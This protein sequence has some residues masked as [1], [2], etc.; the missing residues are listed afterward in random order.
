MFW[1]MQ[2]LKSYT[3]RNTKKFFM[4]FVP[5][6]ARIHGVTSWRSILN[7]LLF[8]DV[9]NFDLHKSC[10]LGRSGVLGESILDW[11]RWHTRTTKTHRRT[12]I[13]FPCRYVGGPCIPPWSTQEWIRSG[14]RIDPM[15]QESADRPFEATREARVYNF[16]CY[17]Q[18]F[19]SCS[20]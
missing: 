3:V 12:T 1:Q 6:F 14:R 20:C 15:T 11:P 19:W 7:A 9:T 8:C 17:R 2:F 10:C 5:R 18:Y 13:S 4:S 16:S